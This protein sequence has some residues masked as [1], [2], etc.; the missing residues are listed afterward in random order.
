MSWTVV[1][2]W[3]LALNAWSYRQITEGHGTA[4]PFHLGY[5]SLSVSLTMLPHV[6]AIASQHLHKLERKW[7]LK[8]MELSRRMREAE[9]CKYRQA[10]EKTARPLPAGEMG[11]Q[12]PHETQQQEVQSPAPGYVSLEEPQYKTDMDLSKRAPFY[13]D[14]LK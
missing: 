13:E 6:T 3:S 10:V 1:K 5:N 12:G 11:Q 4:I 2:F 7:D 8:Y 9:L 14:S